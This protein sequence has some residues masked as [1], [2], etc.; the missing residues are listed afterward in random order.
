M[1]YFIYSETFLSLGKN[2]GDMINNVYWSICKVIII[3]IRLQ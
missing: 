1:F 3:L 2:E